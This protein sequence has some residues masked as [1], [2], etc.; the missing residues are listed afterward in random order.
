MLPFQKLYRM[1]LMPNHLAWE[2]ERGRGRG[3]ESSIVS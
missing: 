3:L 2:E 1:G